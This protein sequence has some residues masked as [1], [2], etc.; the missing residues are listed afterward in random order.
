M[1]P[2]IHQVL[3][4]IVLSFSFSLVVYK[5]RDDTADIIHSTANMGESEQLLTDQHYKEIAKIA[6]KRRAGALPIEYLLPE[7][8]LKNLPQNVTNVPRSSG[9]FTHDELEIIETNAEDILQKV[10]E[11]IWT[12]VEVTKAFSK[13]AV[14]AH[15]LVCSLIRLKQTHPL[16]K[17]TDKLSHGNSH[18]RSSQTSRVSR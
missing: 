12:S 3:D 4:H 17:T 14:V 13:A 16:I 8:S 2:S 5:M 10:R 1:A 11:R 15:Q 7:E 18:S 9:H 6:Q